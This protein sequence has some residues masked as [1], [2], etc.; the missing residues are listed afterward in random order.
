MVIEH[1]SVGW[2]MG[3]AAAA[4]HTGCDWQTRVTGSRLA[5]ERYRRSRLTAAQW[6]DAIVATIE[7]VRAARPH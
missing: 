2:W 7:T 3:T 5:W 4:H 6:A 1:P